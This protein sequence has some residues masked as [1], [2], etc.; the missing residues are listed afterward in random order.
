M[1]LSY[2]YMT[3]LC[4]IATWLRSGFSHFPTASIRRNHQTKRIM[5]YLLSSILRWIFFHQKKLTSYSQLQALDDIYASWHTKDTATPPGSEFRTSYG[6]VFPE[7]LWWN[8]EDGRCNRTKTCSKRTCFV[9]IGR[10]VW[11]PQI[12]KMDELLQALGIQSYCQIMIRASN[13]LQ[14]ATYLD[15]HS[16]TIL[17][18][19][20][21]RWLD[22]FVGKGEVP[23]S[24][25]YH[26]LILLMER[27]S[28][29]A[30]K[31]I[32]LSR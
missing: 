14:N 10:V 5:N 18:R 6:V 23:S 9:S 15:S 3:S 4:F 13:H 31:L 2:I 27:K 30:I 16:I 1:V 25:T 8:S 17:R 22:G 11:N 32:Y 21:L 29:R 19:D 26:D 7:S 12:W 20:I 24:G 28:A